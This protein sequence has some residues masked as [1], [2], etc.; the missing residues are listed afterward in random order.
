MYGDSYAAGDNVANEDCYP[1][2]LSAISGAE[3][4]NYGVSG[5]GTDQHL[6][7]HRKFGWDVEADL[8]MV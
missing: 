8:V 7:I 5:T 2:R 4:Y 6:L 1:D 3:V